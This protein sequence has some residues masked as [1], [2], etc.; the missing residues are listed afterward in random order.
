MRISIRTWLLLL[1][2]LGALARAYDIS[3]PWK[4]KDHY[5]FGGV[6]IS[7]MA[8]CLQTTPLE[9]SKGV[10]HGRCELGM[11]DPYPNH[12][13]TIL[14]AVNMWK[15]MWGSHAEWTYRSFVMIFSWLNILLVFLI[16]SILYPRSLIPYGAAAI[17]SLT[18]GGLYF[19]THPDFICE[20]AVFFP[21][22]GSYLYLRSK[23]HWAGLVT[24]LGGLASWPGFIFF[25]GQ[26][27][28][29]W[30][31]KKK[32]APLVLWGVIGALAGLALMMWLQ[33]TFDIGEFLRRKL[34]KPGYL[35]ATE[36]KNSF[37]VLDWIKTVFQYHSN[38]LSPAFLM[39]LLLELIATTAN[40]E[41]NRKLVGTIFL[42]GGGG[43]LYAIIGQQ[44]VYVHAFLYLYL[45]PLYSILIAQWIFRCLNSPETLAVFRRQQWILIFLPIFV[46]LMYPFG[47]LQSNFIHDVCNSLLLVGA[48]M[49]FVVLLWKG[50][51][52]EKKMLVVLTVAAIGNVSQ[53]VNYRNEPA[54]D[55]LFCQQARE[56]FAKT[57][58]PVLSPLDHHFARDFYC[59]EIPLVEPAE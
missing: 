17:Q 48:T 11:Q 29:V 20:F 32:K 26:A 36:E 52:T 4:R 22:F 30:L 57:G 31:S 6:M 49:G 21:L 40:R 53:M 46:F 42:I 1:I 38:Y 10:P 58:Q 8:E 43:L 50:R 12:P 56:Q 18:I 5:N 28:Y 24:V 37:Y 45:F 3:A 55:Y 2:A 19:G 35:T 27:V 34:V 9:I 39:F 16:G 51:L 13:P 25:G 41:W 14:F 44:Y 7:R 15:T 33:Q 47:R 59:R 54:K 23:P